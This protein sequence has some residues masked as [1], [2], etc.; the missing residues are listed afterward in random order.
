LSTFSTIS[1][2]D[3]ILLFAWPT[4]LHLQF[5]RVTEHSALSVHFALG[6]TLIG[7]RIWNYSPFLLSDR[8]FYDK[9][10]S[11]ISATQRHLTDT[12]VSQQW[13]HFKSKSKRIIQTHSIKQRSLHARAIRSLLSKL[14]RTNFL[15]KTLPLF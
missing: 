13:D 10:I 11:F 8:K 5:I 6:E 2:I 3:H 7:P 4:V 1:T 15:S 14:Y 12:G 9:L